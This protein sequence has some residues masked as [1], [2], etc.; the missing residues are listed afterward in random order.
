MTIPLRPQWAA[1]LLA[2]LLVLSIPAAAAETTVEDLRMWAA[3]PT[4]T[5]PTGGLPTTSIDVRMVEDGPAWL[6]DYGV[7][8]A[9][10][11]TS[12]FA[13]LGFLLGT[14]WSHHLELRRAD[15][16]E[17]READAVRN[18]VAAEVAVIGNML[19]A[20]AS[21]IPEWIDS[22][23]AKIR[24]GT[25]TPPQQ[26]DLSPAYPNFSTEIYEAYV[27]RIHVLTPNAPNAQTDLR[28]LDI[29]HFYGSARMWIPGIRL[30]IQN[31][32]NLT[33][34]RPAVEQL[35]RIHGELVGLRENAKALVLDLRQPMKDDGSIDEIYTDQVV[36]SDQIES[37]IPPLKVRI[38]SASSAGDGRAGV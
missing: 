18:A 3:I 25:F 28:V 34:F 8:F 12:V 21:A 6:R 10:L 17:A 33:D 4:T 23:D 38:P 24:K 20:F 1:I 29:V 13:F 31:L 36:A 35:R 16:R 5:Q 7:L 2:T 32:Q 15:R 9:A 19:D 27:G 37:I 30:D 26:I 14:R 22:C 11:I